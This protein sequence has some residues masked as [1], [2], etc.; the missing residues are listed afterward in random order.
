MIYQAEEK[1]RLNYEYL[2]LS[3]EG[4]SDD[5]VLDAWFRVEEQATHK[6]VNRAAKAQARVQAP[7]WP[8]IAKRRQREKR[9][10]ACLARRALES[11]EWEPFGSDEAASKSV[12]RVEAVEAVEEAVKD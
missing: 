4:E 12:E 5:R 10:K 6:V 11:E 3:G 9:V 1:I 8:K 2:N 7:S